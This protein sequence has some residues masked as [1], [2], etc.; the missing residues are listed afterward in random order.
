MPDPNQNN[1][2]QNPVSSTVA[3]VSSVDQPV[4][5]PSDDPSTL[6]ITPPPVTPPI[7]PIVTPVNIPLTTSETQTTDANNQLSEVPSFLHSTDLPPL[8]PDFQNISPD[9]DPIKKTEDKNAP[10]TNSG[11]NAPLPDLPITTGSPKKKFGGGKIIA[12]ILGLFLLVG[13]IAGG[14]LLTQQNQNLNERAGGTDYQVDPTNCGSP[15]N[16]CGAGKGCVGGACVTVNTQT[17]PKNCGEAGFQCASGATCVNGK[18]GGS[19]YQTDPNNCGGPGNNC[20]TRSCVNGQCVSSTNTTCSTNADCSSGQ[21]CQ[22]GQCSGFNCTAPSAMV[23]GICVP[24]GNCQHHTGNCY[25]TNDIGANDGNDGS[26]PGSYNCDG[27]GH[28]TTC[29]QG[30]TCSN[31]DCVPNATHTNP[32]GSNPPATTPPTTP[33]AQCQNIKAYSST[34][35]LLTDAQLSALTPSTV[36]NFCVLG[37]ASEGTFDSAKFTINTVTQAETTT[38]RPTTN[39]FCQS[40]AIPAGV[41]SFNITAQIHHAT[42]GWK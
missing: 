9:V 10:D 1:D 27:N 6:P 2:N 24:P 40:Y 36:V 8:A 21:T 32:P 37:S 23:N 31:E 38:K 4:T 28:W 14:V 15:G 30:Y 26:S 11:S 41:T 3:D 25:V 16:Q 29:A 7:D 20:G 12:T 18:C 22:N 19:Q 13:G 5:T 42:L 33:T 34:W 35:T 39:D 17:D